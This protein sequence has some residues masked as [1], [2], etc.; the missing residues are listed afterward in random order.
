MA[1]DPK[2]LAPIVAALG[3]LRGGGNAFMERWR[4]LEQ[5]KAQRQQQD[6]QA[7]IRDEQFGFQ[8]DANARAQAGDVRAGQDQALQVANSVRGLLEDPTI[9]DPAIFDQRMQ[10]ASQL[11]P[12]LGVDPGFLQS[13]R[14]APTVFQ[15]RQARKKLKEIQSSYSASQLA[16]LESDDDTGAAPVFEVGGEQLTLGQLRARAEVGATRGGQPVSLKPQENTDTPTPGS[17]EDY[18]AAPPERR[19]AIE[20]A[21]T[22]Y[23]AAGREPDRP[24]QG[25]P[26]WV[27]TAS[28]AVR[29]RIP[30]PG[31]VPR[32]PVAERQGGDDGPTPYA[33]ERS[34]RTIQSVDDL[35]SKVSGWT[36]GYGSLLSRIPQT[37]AANFEAELETLKANIAFNELTAMRE[38]SKTGG[39]LGQVSNIE[40]GLLTSALGA[41]RSNQSPANLRAQ[42][43]KIRA[44]V[45][46]WRAAQGLPE[47]LDPGGSV[48]EG[49]RPAGRGAGAGPATGATRRI[50]RFE[51][52]ERP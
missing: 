33:A 39:A 50:G 20:Q 23:N 46:R 14:P 5:Q 45:N 22:Q 42:L 24:P 15:Q 40:L 17:F 13:L 41:L 38:A 52:V 19:T 28:G 4:E 1:F 26:Q 12:R 6:E 27:K 44:S 47:I 3:G 21:R 31:D 43:R 29:Y 32:D 7:A 30:Q 35:V 49:A 9:D 2:K 8:R 36:T 51:V 34:A 25:S 48:T 18:L 11:A 10:F 16:M 37:D